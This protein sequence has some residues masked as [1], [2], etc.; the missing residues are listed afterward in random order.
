MDLDDTG[1]QDLG[2]AA[3]SAFVEIKQD[4]HAGGRVRYL[5]RLP[6][7]RSM[8]QIKRSAPTIQNQKAPT[9]NTSPRE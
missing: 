6:L 9:S 7:L 1:K 5:R 8:H 4:G 3:D 2:K